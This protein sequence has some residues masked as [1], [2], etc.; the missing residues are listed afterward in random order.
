LAHGPSQSES[1]QIGK[2]IE[3]VLEFYSHLDG[4]KQRGVRARQHRPGTEGPWQQS[5]MLR[6]E[7]SDMGGKIDKAEGKVKKTLKG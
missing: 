7:E 4:R 6:S 5:A 2:N 3:D 1:D